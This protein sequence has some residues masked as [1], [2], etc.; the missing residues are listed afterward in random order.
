MLPHAPSVQM[1]DIP[2]DGMVLK[3]DADDA[4][5]DKRNPVQIKDKQVKIL[6]H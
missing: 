6:T 2:P 4:D 3:E 1:A 5:P